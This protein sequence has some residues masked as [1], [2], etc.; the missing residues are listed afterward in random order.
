MN[1]TKIHN[2]PMSIEIQTSRIES[3]VFGILS[4]WSALNLFQA[5]KNFINKSDHILNLFQVFFILFKTISATVYVIFFNLDCSPRAILVNLPLLIAWDLIYIIILNRVLKFTLNPAIVKLIFIILISL[6][7][8]IGF[9]GSLLGTFK[10]TNGKC[11]N[12]YPIIYKQQ[13]I[14]EILLELLVII[15][16]FKTILV[17]NYGTIIERSKQAFL[18]L[19]SNE[20]FRIFIVLFFIFIKIILSYGLTGGILPF[21]PLALTHFIDSCRSAF[22]CWIIINNY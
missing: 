1:R 17:N 16:I 5:S 7:F 6:H 20:E 2:F 15:E 18:E 19:K 8:S 13:Y 3:A 22:I 4:A 14:I 21:N 10:S 12:E 9:S 11:S